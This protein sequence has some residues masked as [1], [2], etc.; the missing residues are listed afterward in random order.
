[1]A[2]SSSSDVELARALES[3]EKSEH[4]NSGL[5]AKISSLGDKVKVLQKRISKLE[6]TNKEVSY[7]A[8]LSR[9]SSSSVM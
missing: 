1:M 5:R 7:H 8:P 3:L 9:S 6:E 2:T 4:Q